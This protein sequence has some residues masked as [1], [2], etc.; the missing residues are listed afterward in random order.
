MRLI[1]NFTPVMIKMSEKVA[2]FDKQLSDLNRKIG[3]LDRS[4]LGLKTT[5]AETGTAFTGAFGKVDTAISSS[6]ALVRDLNAELRATGVAAAAAG[7]NAGAVPTGVRAR[8]AHAGGGGVGVRGPGVGVP[9][10]GSFHMGGTAGMVGIG[11]LGYGALEAAR[12]DS[13]INRMLMTGGVGGGGPLHQNQ[14]YAPLRDAILESYSQTGMPLDQIEE[15]IKTGTR[16]LSGV[17]FADRLKIMPQLLR[18][19]STEAYLKEG[20]TL[21]EAMEAFVG[22]GH[23][24][25]QYTP[26]GL[27]ALSEHFAYLS[28]TTPASVK[29]LTRASSYAIPMLRTADFDPAQILLMLTSMER[30]GIGNTKAGTW[31]GQLATQSFPGTSLMSKMLFKK[32]ESALRDLGLVDE[33]DKPT[34]FTNGRPDLVKMTGIAG[35]HIQAMDPAHRLAIEK[36]LWGQQGGRAAALFADPTTRQ[37]MANVAGEEKNFMPGEAMWR[38]TQANDPLI[39]LRRAGADLNTF[40]IDLGTVALPMVL[41]P[42]HALDEVLKAISSS[43]SFVDKMLGHSVES[44]KLVNRGANAPWWMGPTWLGVGSIVGHLG[45]ALA[46]TFGSPANATTMKNM[47]DIEKRRRETANPADIFV[48][49]PKSGDW[50]DMFKGATLDALKE[51]SAQAAKGA[52]GAGLFGGGGGGFG[53]GIGGTG[54][55]GHAAAAIHKSLRH[56]HAL[57]AAAHGGIGTQAG[58]SAYLNFLAAAP[59]ANITDLNPEFAGR[60]HAFQSGLEAQGI[61][62]RI[63]SGFR[64]HALQAQLYARHLAGGPLAARPGHSYHERGMAVDM[65]PIGGD[66][67]AQLA[68][69]ARIAPLYGIYP[70]ANFGDRD[71]FEM[72]HGL[73]P[74]RPPQDGRRDRQSSNVYLDKKKVGRVMWDDLHRSASGPSHGAQIPD[75]SRGTY[76]SSSSYN[77]SF[78]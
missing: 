31:I 34:W 72:S 64:S 19:A 40:L 76:G 45:D 61:H 57:V 25:G 28:T 8:A 35:E 14:Y 44:D 36:A 18:S 47:A 54:G 60:V 7:R 51:W 71:H 9:G 58:R 49:T 74:M 42:L 33:N 53:F 59:G 24:T 11:A 10:G 66:Q 41:P 62:T 48:G 21:K 55:A 29:E 68:A 4:F 30:A 2:L 69:M 73:V 70:G 3:W 16:G 13:A 12:L 5:T 65:L 37:I 1:D 50:H 27:G 32:H 6:L 17:P 39:Q 26:K 78:V 20:T 43:A 75:G 15:A 63:I 38:T 56:G 22:L 52:D 77:V 46:H 67:A 23:M